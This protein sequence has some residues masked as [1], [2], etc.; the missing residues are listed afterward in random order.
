VLAALIALT[1]AAAAQAVDRRFRDEP[2]GGVALPATPLAGEHDGRALSVNPAGLQFL[3]GPEALLVLEYADADHASAGGTGGGLIL[4]GPVGGGLLPRLGLGVGLEALRPARARL[5]PDPG[6]PLRAS[7]GASFWMTRNLALGVTWHHFF[8]DGPLDGVDALDLGL[9]ARLGNHVA[10]GAVVR[11]LNAPRVLAELVQRRY[12]VEATLRPLGSDSLD[13]GVGGR[14]GEIDGNVDGWARGSLRLTRGLYAHLAVETR[15]QTTVTTSGASMV[16]EDGRD[17]R[18]TLGLEL[19]LGGF[20]VTTY[21]SSLRDVGGES[22]TLGGGVML[23]SSLVEVP[24]LVSPTDHIE[25]VELEGSLEGFRMVSLVSRLRAIGRDRSTRAVALVF[26]DFSAGWAALHEL[27][28]ELAALRGRGIKLYA[29]LVTADTRDYYLASVADKIYLDPAGALNLT[30]VASSTTYWRGALDLVGVT[31][32]FEK[33]AEYKSAPEQFTRR[34]P[35]APADRMREELLDGIWDEVVTA[36]AA[37]RQLS[38]E[39]VKALV[40]RGPFSAGDLAAM[41]ASVSPAVGAAA[42]PGS[43]GS[44]E[45]GTSGAAAGSEGRAASAA[46]STPSDAIGSNAA[47]GA[48]GS[49]SGRAT[50]GAD[51]E[52][53]APPPAG[54]GRPPLIDAVAT[55]ERAALLIAQDLGTLY[56]VRGPARERPAQWQR[57]KIAVVHVEGDIV[58]GKSQRLPVLDRKMAGGETVSEAIAAARAAP[59]VG[60]IILRID[61]PGGSALASELIAREVFATRGVKPILCSMSNVAASGGYFAAAGC[62]LIFAEPTTVTGSIGIF[63]GKADLSGLM[64][65]LGVTVNVDKRGALADVGSMVRPYTEEERARLKENIRYT[66]GRFVGA[67]AEGRGMTRQQVDEVGRGRVWTGLRAKEVGLVDRLGGIGDAIE[68]ARKRMRAGEGERVELVQLPYAAPGLVQQLLRSTGAAQAIQAE[69][70]LGVGA[71]AEL[72]SL[73]AGLMPSVLWQP[74]VAQ[75]RLPFE[76][77][78]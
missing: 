25:R 44:G 65:K 22:R 6:T 32:E 29:F 2:T 13:L 39:Q 54:A 73:L 48:A 78:W 53:G 72:R 26:D 28:D 51:Q 59:E 58:D 14:V 38:P 42:S 16:E 75:A 57:R 67:V 77:G 24:S 23:R 40:D 63:F 61:S 76:L 1:E 17:V 10:L 31:P 19:S 18:A 52:G 62:E 12:E 15:G 69:A 64:G 8:D 71:A 27:R 20:G 49:A 30:G 3:R 46:A 60:A 11:D 66:Y 37:S 50:R 43:G 34:G 68:E 47:V 36:I 74:E 35:S 55:P 5:L 41:A 45:R 56:P 70:G 7:L 33:I 9:S 21:A 4:A